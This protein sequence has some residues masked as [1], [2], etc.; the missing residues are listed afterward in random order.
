MRTIP[1]IAVVLFLLPG[2]ASAQKDELKKQLVG[3]WEATLKDAAEVDF[4]FITEFKEDGKMVVTV[5]GIKL[6]GTWTVVDDKTIKTETL[7]PDG[8]K[9]P[10]TQEAKIVGDTLQLKD[11]T[12]KPFELKRVK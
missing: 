9:K 2:T 4:K 1:L 5:K 7:L 6:P 10:A 12:G 11:G 3:T 8:T